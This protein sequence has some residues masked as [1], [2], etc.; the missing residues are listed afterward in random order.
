MLFCENYTEEQD[1]VLIHYRASAL[2]RRIKLEIIK[3]ERTK[4]AVY[5]AGVRKHTLKVYSVARLPLTPGIAI[6]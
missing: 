6:A 2:R 5:T 1:L 4:T 3:T